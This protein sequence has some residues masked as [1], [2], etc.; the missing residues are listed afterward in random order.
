MVSARHHCSQ[1]EITIGQVRDWKGMDKEEW[2]FV[3][4][5]KEKKENGKENKEEGVIK[6]NWGRGVGVGICNE[7]VDECVCVS[8]CTNMYGIRFSFVPCF[9][10]LFFFTRVL[11]F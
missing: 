5:K 8:V 11:Q 3:K 4:K 2:K 1:K 10:F 7:R 9:F 6:N